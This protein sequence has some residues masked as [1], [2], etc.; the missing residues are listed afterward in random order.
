MKIITREL[1]LVQANC[2]VL[3]ENNHALLIDPGDRFD[4]LDTILSNEEATLDAILLTHA[5]FDHIAGV[6]D[7]LKRHDVDVYLNPYEHSFL[8]DADLNASNG[9]LRYVV[10]NAR[11][12]TLEQGRMQIGNFDLETIHCPGHS[13]GSTV[14]KIDNKLF[15]GDVL[16]YGSIGRTDLPT[17]SQYS[18]MKSLKLLTDLK[19]DFEVYPGHGP[20]TSLDLE[21]KINPFLQI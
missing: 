16:F 9:F 17:G 2:Y 1:G 18:M 13:I 15:T 4:E 5:H 3:I 19:E 11:P 12:K 20:K 7:I 14:F 6:D 21:R 10:C 8:T